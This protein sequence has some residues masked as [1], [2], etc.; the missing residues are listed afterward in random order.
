MQGESRADIGRFQILAELGRG[1]FATVYR[2]YDPHLGRQ[3]AIKI[4]HP[5][6]AQDPT[7]VSRFQTEARAMAR[8][9]HPHIVTVYEA[10]TAEDGRTF[11][12]MELIDGVPLS[13]L[14]TREA[15]IPLERAVAMLK[16][17]ASA[18]DYLHS[19]GIVHR[20]LK[21]ANVMIGAYGEVVLMD[22]GIAKQL[23]GGA[24]PAAE[25]GAGD[26][27]PAGHARRGALFETVAGQLIGTPAYMSPEQARG[28]PV[29]ERS[30]LYS[31]SMVFHELLCL[32]HPLAEKQT[33]AEMLHGVIEEPAPLAGRVHSPHQAAVGMDLSWFLRRGLAKRPADR[34]QSATE[35]IERLARRAEGEVPVQ[36]HITLVMRMNGMW[37]RFVSRHPIVVTL[38]MAAALIALVTNVVLTVMRHRG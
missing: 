6:L 21:P 36:C 12:V 33:L 37:S 35:M 30:D 34:F 29:D 23:R 8:L 20:D 10:S 25:A 5:H 16:Q 27:H 32:K 11:L 19:Q 24:A 31:L 13:E 26:L 22:W 18:V 1:G 7:F 38:G 17:L 15:P 3:I 14:V 28:E 9:R 2:A 4:L